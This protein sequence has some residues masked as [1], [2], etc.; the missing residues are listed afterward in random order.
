VSAPRQTKV[1][2]SFFDPCRGLRRRRMNGGKA[3]R[4]LLV[5]LVQ[6]AWLAGPQPRRDDERDG[7]TRASG[8]WIHR[9][10]SKRRQLGRLR[11]WEEEAVRVFNPNRHPLI[12]RRRG[13]DGP[14]D[15]D[16]GQLGRASAPGAHR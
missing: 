4:S 5:D 16:A 14:S 13:L 9:R 1:V 10:A 3:M 15:D 12:R 8:S 7:L 11:G 2:A 6:R